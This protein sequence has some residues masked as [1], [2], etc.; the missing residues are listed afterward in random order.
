MSKVSSVKNLEK[1]AK[2]NDSLSVYMYDNGFMVEVSGSDNS[3]EWVTVKL[4]C[5]TLDEVYDLI[6][7]TSLIPRSR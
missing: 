3:D 6:K 2:C 4:V 5:N 1:L 7:Q